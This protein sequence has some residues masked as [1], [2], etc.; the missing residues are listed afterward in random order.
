MLTCV[1]KGDSWR[2]LQGS[3]SDCWTGSGHQCQKR[4]RGQPRT[5]SCSTF[6]SVVVTTGHEDCWRSQFGGTSQSTNQLVER[7]P[8]LDSGLLP[9]SPAVSLLVMRG[10][11]LAEAPGHW[12]GIEGCQVSEESPAGPF[13]ANPKRGGQKA[14]LYSPKVIL[15]AKSEIRVIYV[16]YEPENR[17]C[18]RTDSCETDFASSI[19]FGNLNFFSA[20]LM[21]RGP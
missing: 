2:C 10:G 18:Q 1:L 8:S 11:E 14:L 16:Q 9:T 3:G 12:S 17:V 21:L 5:R 19:T 20:A 7:V 4:P 15:L 6:S 13:R